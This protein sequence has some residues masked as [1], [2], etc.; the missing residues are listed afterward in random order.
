MIKRKPVLDELAERAYATLAGLDRGQ[1]VRT[2]ALEEATGLR[3]YEGCWGSVVKRLKAHA[4]ERRNIALWA[5]PEVG[6]KLCTK[7]EQLKMVPSKRQRR[8]ARQ[9]ARAVREV[10]A[11]PAGELTL[12]QQQ[13]RAAELEQMRRSQRQLRRHLREQE[14]LSR[15]RGGLDGG[16]HRVGAGAEAAAA[17]S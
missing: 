9:I 7:D 4:L 11:L 3:R 5:V 1:V 15:P 14:I 12:H 6:Y 17:T 13:L 8:A 10:G 16:G 2:E